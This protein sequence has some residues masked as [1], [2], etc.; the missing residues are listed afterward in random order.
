[1]TFGA[2]VIP[3]TMVKCVN[4]KASACIIRVGTTVPA[5]KT[6]MNLLASALQAGPV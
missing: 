2:I 4:M 6:E 5:R 1:M 3:G